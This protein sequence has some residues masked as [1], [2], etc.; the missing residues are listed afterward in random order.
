MENGG[1][2]KEQLYE[3]LAKYFSDNATEIEAQQLVEWKS[4][5]AENRAEFDRFEKIWKNSKKAPSFNT[6]KAWKAV[7][8]RI[9]ASETKIVSIKRRKDSV[10]KYAVAACV[11]LLFS[12][13]GFYFFNSGQIY[14]A[15]EGMLAVALEDGTA[16]DINKNGEIKLSSN[17]NDLERRVQ[18]KGEAFFDVAKNKEK[19]FVIETDLVQVSV[20]GTSFNV[21]ENEDSVVVTV[22]SGVVEVSDNQSTNNKRKLLKGDRLVFRNNNRTFKKLAFDENALAWKT[23][24]IVFRRTYLKNVFKVVEATYGVEVEL[25]NSSIENCQLTAQFEDQPLEVVLAVIESTFE[26]KIEKTDSLVKISGEGCE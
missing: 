7:Q 22:V 15:Q 25:S 18:L 13:A 6:E 4:A 1:L 2:N 10:L 8:S 20:L 5:S 23:R 17:F 19:P 21:N 9:N 26:L 3:L 14:S 12:V 11:V 24:T 16:I